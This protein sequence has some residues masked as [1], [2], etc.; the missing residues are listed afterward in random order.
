MTSLFENEVS[1]S[2]HVV[3]TP[4]KA[5]VDTATSAGLPVVSSTPRPH[6]RNAH[7]RRCHHQRNSWR[8]GLPSLRSIRLRSRSLHQDAPTFKQVR[9]DICGFHLVA[10]PCD[11][12]ASITACG[13]SV[14]SASQSRN[15]ER[16]PCGT[17]GSFRA[18]VRCRVREGETPDRR[19]AFELLLPACVV[20]Q[21][22]YNVSAEG[23]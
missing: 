14:N 16:K 22:R 17:G 7:H 1:M 9:A 18:H 21:I 5:R 13:A 15:E 20:V 11:N 23:C 8:R 4:A 6:R 12:A 19:S 10:G 2:K 3:R